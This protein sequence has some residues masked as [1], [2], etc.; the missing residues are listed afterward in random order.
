MANKRDEFNRDTIRRAA[1]RVG[2]KCS[3]CGCATVGPSYDTHDAVSSIGVASHICAAAVGGPR[4]DSTMTPEQR[5]SIDNCIW[6]C[7][8][9]S[10]LIDTDEAKYTVEYLKELKRN[11]ETRAHNELE[12]GRISS[13]LITNT[14]ETS[15]VFEQYL[16]DLIIDGNYSEILKYIES[17][18]DVTSEKLK[19]LY[20]RYKVIYDCYCNRDNLNDDLKNYLKL[21]VIE[22]INILIGHFIILHLNDALSLSIDY[23]NDEEL[24][25]MAK[26]II[27]DKIFESWFV[28]G[29]QNEPFEMSENIQHI[30][31]K[32]LSFYIFKNEMLYIKYSDGKLFSFESDNY[33]FELLN[34]VRYLAIYSDCNSYECFNE[35]FSIVLN[36]MRNSNFNQLDQSIQLLIWQ[37]VLAPLPYDKEKYEQLYNLCPSV[38]KEDDFIQKYNYLHLIHFKLKDLDIDSFLQFIEKTS[39]YLLL[40]CYLSYLSKEECNAFLDE[41]KYLYRKSNVLIFRKYCSLPNNNKNEILS[42]IEQY[43]TYYDENDLII[44][45]ILLKETSDAK[46]KVFLLQNINSNNSSQFFGSFVFFLI[47]VLQENQEW[48]TLLTLSKTVVFYPS[49]LLKIAQVLASSNET[50]WIIESEKIL[51]NLISIE[52][53]TVILYNTIGIVKRKIGKISEALDYLKQGYDIF[54]SEQTLYHFLSLR[55]EQNLF[56]DDYYLTEAKKNPN[57]SYIV[58]CFSMKLNQFTEAYKYF[59]R[60]LLLNENNRYSINGLNF[61][62]FNKLINDIEVNAV[63]E[64]TIIHIENELE[65]K[66]IALHNKEILNNIIPNHFA[67]CIHH[68]IEDPEVAEYMFCKQNDKITYNGN[69]YR[70]T[71]IESVHRY[72]AT[73][74]FKLFSDDPSTIHLSF[75]NGEELIHKITEIVKTQQDE[76]NENINHYND[77]NMIIPIEIFKDA[78]GTTMLRC[79]E[80][81]LFE[82]KKRIINNCKNVPIND[83]TS[84]ILSYDSIISIAH[85]GLWNLSEKENVCIPM[86]VKLQLLD[87]IENELQEIKVDNHPGILTYSNEK[88]VFIE[89]TIERK[90]ERFSF[91]TRIKKF[92]NS[93]KTYEAYDFEPEIEDFKDLYKENKLTELSSISLAKNLPNSIVVTDNC[94]LYSIADN[95]GVK[96]I[97]ICIFLSKILVDWKKLLDV[98]KKLAYMNFT[99]YI[100]YEIYE[101]MMIMFQNQN[102]TIDDL[103][104][105]QNWLLPNDESNILH[106]LNVMNLYKNVIDSENPTLNPNNFLLNIAWKPLKYPNPSLSSETLEVLPNTID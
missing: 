34:N 93:I 11:A 32:A 27:D 84:Y 13:D 82:N 39:N 103:T 102:G 59:L 7:Q 20:Y 55:F 74:A 30:L 58:G 14:E 44:N 2:Y 33:F 97:G 71:K 28:S 99:N 91:L 35:A 45:S 85:L 60:S 8:T 89:N 86:Q 95:E 106:Y 18:K 22:G 48:N 69:I 16:D 31:N 92:I 65:T 25:E 63:G 9:H 105:I 19:E 43:K 1:K 77:T 53:K 37:H 46:T 38:F 57:L 50:K 73:F 61:I 49:I 96:N 21:N 101:S 4:Y 76:L 41:H 98:Q 15:K 72:F 70:I 90:K 5:K 10:R 94:F 68:S 66:T 67:N 17:I 104:I 12:S 56:K 78:L 81:L 54:K 42:I 87:D 24:I 26:V 23:C 36:G 40:D 52:Y 100:P 80:F 79:W 6:M 62:Y 3:F 51:D 47:E 75:T 64:D 29:K 88:A 83:N